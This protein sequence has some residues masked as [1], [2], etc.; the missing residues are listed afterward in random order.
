MMKVFAALGKS[1][2]GLICRKGAYKGTYFR[3][4]QRAMHDT[5]DPAAGNE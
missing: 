4:E 5:R 2:Q 1:C 3:D